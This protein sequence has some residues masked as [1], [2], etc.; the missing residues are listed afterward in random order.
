MGLKKFI[1]FFRSNSEFVPFFDW[2]SR[3][4]IPI[5]EKNS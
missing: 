5:A 2:W 1:D 3:L 4:P